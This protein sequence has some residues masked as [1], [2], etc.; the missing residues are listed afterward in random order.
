MKISEKIEIALERLNEGSPESYAD[1]TAAI[2]LKK[3]SIL[4]I[5]KEHI[6]VT[7]SSKPDDQVQVFLVE[8]DLS[9]S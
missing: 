6:K 3:Q 2:E 7:K 5:A 4:M 1:L 8:L 9:D